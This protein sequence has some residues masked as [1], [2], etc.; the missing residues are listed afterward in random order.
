M[1]DERTLRTA[2]AADGLR[3]RLGDPDGARRPLLRG[4]G[5]HDHRDRAVAVRGRPA[6]GDRRPRRD[7]RRRGQQ[8][9]R[10]GGAG[11]GRGPRDGLPGHRP[12]RP[13]ARRVALPR[14]DGRGAVRARRRRHGRRPGGHA[15]RGRSP[16]CSPRAARRSST[17]TP[18][19][20]AQR[21]TK[22]AEE[23]ERL[24]WCAHLTDL[25]QAAA[26]RGAR[27]GRTEL[28]VW[29]D[30]RLAMEA[31]EGRARPDR[32]RPHVRDRLD[33]RA[34]AAGRPTA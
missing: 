26:L 25:G 20:T 3:R 29:A 10:G 6:L 11:L 21:C 28:E 24:R 27:P 13:H 31:E 4:P 12:A 32:G 15:S 5:R 17:S 33:R 18:S 14:R 23:I 7:A 9:R 22:T 30:V 34:S 19:S 8:P 2:E 1:T 16:S